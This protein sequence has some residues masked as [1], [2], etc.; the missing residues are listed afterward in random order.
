MIYL[1][2]DPQP[3]L[4][5]R[6]SMNE[7]H[8]YT[9]ICCNMLCLCG[10]CSYIKIHFYKDKLFTLTFLKSLPSFCTLSSGQAASALYS[11]Y[12]ATAPLQ[13]SYRNVT[14]YTQTYR[15]LLLIT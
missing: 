14:H 2:I 3:S 5:S 8:N 11:H 4:S 9:I 15:V 1:N 13:P 10:I 6:G 7:L 12:I